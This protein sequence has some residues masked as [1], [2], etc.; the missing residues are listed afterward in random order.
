MKYWLQILKMCPDR[1]AKKCYLMLMN[2]DKHG[3][4]ISDKYEG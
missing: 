3:H 4:R 2:D 1:Y